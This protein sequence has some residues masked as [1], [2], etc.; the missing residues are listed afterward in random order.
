MTARRFETVLV[1]GAAGFVGRHL[2]RHLCRAE[3]GPGRVVAWDLRVPDD[4]DAARVADWRRVD[5][6]DAGQA[7]QAL[8]EAAPNAVLH[9]AGLARSDDLQAYF[10]ANVTACRNL[11]AW[12]A[13][14][15]DPPRVLVVGSA[16]QYGI[17]R[18]GEEVM[19]ESRP[20]ASRSP[21]GVTKTMQERWALLAGEATG[22]PVVA[23]R[24]FNI[25]GP[26]QPPTLVP[27]AFLHQVRDVLAG[28]Q[29]AVRVGN[30]ETCR[31]FTDVRDVV[32]A[33]WSLVAAEAP[34][35]GA[36][37]NIASGEAVRIGDMLQFCLDLAGTEVAV[38]VDKRR[39]RAHDVSVIV[40]DASRL[41]KAVG[42]RPHIPW[43]TSL[44]DAWADLRAA[45]VSGDRPEGR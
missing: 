35:E 17:T 3:D 37:Y 29:E 30:V 1:T 43:R 22:V 41:R 44:E 20:L 39:L 34:A 10:R 4:S 2:L 12:A 45:A 8:D 26:G 7:A 27:G 28:R 11:L 14:Q 19:A 16:A 9:L 36:V 31:D 5:F 38:K 42:W 23:V 24:P 13:E 32:A 15:A 6:A 25:M 40:G 21:Y 33:L 18:G